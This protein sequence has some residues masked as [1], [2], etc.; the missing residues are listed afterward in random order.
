M[1]DT[2]QNLIVVKRSGQRV[3]FNSLKIAV[4]IKKGFNDISSKYS[5][6][7]INKVFEDTMKYITDNYKNRKTINVEDIQD[8]IEN[9]LKNDNYKD[10]YELFSLYRIRRSESR[11]AFS[12]KSQHK[13][14]KAIEKMGLIKEED[15]CPNELLNKYALTVATE[16]TKAY[17]LDNKYLRAHDEGKIFIHDLV[18]FNLG[19]LSSSHL[20]YQNYLDNFDIH[21]L[22]ILCL[23]AKKE[24]QGEIALDDFNIALNNYIQEKYKKI[25]KETIYNY[26]NLLG[27]LEYINYKKIEDIIDKQTTIYI[28]KD[29]FTNIYLNDKTL[30][31]INDAIKHSQNKLLEVFNKEI[32]DFLITLNNNKEINNK[33]SISLI[34]QTNK[35][36]TLI[37]KTILNIIK[38][39]TYL[40]NI[41]LLYKINKNTEED[42][43][44]EISELI[45]LG[46]NIKLINTSSYETKNNSQYFSSSL[47]I[48]DEE[49][50]GRSN[51]A[52]ISINIARLALKYR[53]INNTFYNEL[54]ELLELVKNELL[55][56]FETIG[57]KNVDNYKVLF[58]GNILDDEKLE[59]GQKIRKV[60]KN[61]TLNINLIGL[62]ECLLATS[63]TQNEIIKLLKYI[64]NK[65]QIYTKETKVTYTLS[66]IDDE[67]A[68]QELIQ[69]DKTVFGLIDNITNKTSYENLFD[70][71]LDDIEKLSFYAQ[72]E[73]LLS[74][75]NTITIHISKNTSPK[76]ITSLIKEILKTNISFFHIR[77]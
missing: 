41:T 50:T 3:E 6:K 76:K 1:N 58:K 39:T 11:K 45:S 57:N 59:K 46:K 43:L 52:T 67:L 30:D 27:I 33:Y 29:I 38:N 63:A 13:F 26:L 9:T 72:M 42:I 40:E 21:D 65:T 74:G 71:K 8:I 5:E 69:I 49:V 75:G 16:Y 61:G 77:W 15:N 66:V 23:D 32:K 10:V 19:Y 68:N 17:V 54:D 36:S 62:K 44:L 31:A 51:I 25:L 12:L 22:L 48:S 24:I 20:K 4:A 2:L 70:I 60:I 53:K 47:K 34:D 56:V 64:K 35:E 14:V 55:F 28:S 7:D 18:Y 37:N 73:N